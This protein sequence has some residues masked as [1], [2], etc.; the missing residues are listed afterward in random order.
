[1]L[2]RLTEVG[3]STFSFVLEADDKKAESGRK[4]VTRIEHVVDL[5]PRNQWGGMRHIPDMTA[6]FVQP[7]D[8]AV[9]RLLKQTAELLRLSDKPSAL[10]GYE[11]GAKRAWQL[12]SAVWSAV[13]RMRL[14]YALPPASFEQT[15]QKIRSPSQIADTGLATC[16]I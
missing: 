11:G 5:L 8:P 2:S 7:N 13:A 9:E 4:E 14:D 15:G 1:M 3:L 10:D 6:A 12:A 16:W